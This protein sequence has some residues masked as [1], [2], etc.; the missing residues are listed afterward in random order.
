MMKI[1]NSFI[2]GVLYQLGFYND[3]E[4]KNQDVVTLQVI[5][6]FIEEIEVMQEESKK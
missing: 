1:W 4:V 5:D 6:D 2:K 3:E